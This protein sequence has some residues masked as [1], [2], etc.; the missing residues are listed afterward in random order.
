M[1][2][3]L[4]EQGKVAAVAV[5]GIDRTERK[6]AEEALQ[7]AHDEL[8]R[9]VEERTAELT[10]ANEELAVFRRFAEAAGQGFAMADLQ[11][12]IIYANPAI[13]AHD[14]AAKPAEVLGRDLFSL[15][16]ESIGIGLRDEVIP[17][18][19][20]EGHWTGETMIRRGEGR[21]R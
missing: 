6:R 21:P 5:L 14:G 17:A 11:H 20:R 4:D 10:K 8:E 13:V 1:H 16:S 15:H 18:I 2:P 12:Q 9:R 19:L 7:Q 3:I